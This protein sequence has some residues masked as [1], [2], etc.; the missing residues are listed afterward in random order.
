MKSIVIKIVTYNQEDV[1]G[2]ALDSVLRQ[3]EWGLYRIIVSDDCSTDRT[4]DVLQTYHAQYPDLVYIYRNEHNLGM[5]E[6]F[7]KSDSYIPDCDLYS[8]LAGDDEYCDGYFE[9]IQKFIVD[10]NIDTT[11]PIGIFS[12]WKSKSPN[13]VE[14][15]YSNSLIK[16]EY[17]AW[18]LKIRS[19]ITCRSLF[20]SKIVKDRAKPTIL[21]KGLRVA[22][23][24]YDVQSV[25]NIEKT[26]YMP[27]T[28]SIYYTEIGVSRKLNLNNSD[29]L[30]TQNIEKWKSFIELYIS[31][32]RDL[33]YANYE[34]TKSEYL[35]D[36]SW[37]KFFKIICH[38]HKGQLPK[39]K[40]SF[41]RSLHLYL[42]L[43]K[44]KFF[45]KKKA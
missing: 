8:G 4:W 41:N 9:A 28:T 33:N 36:P 35:L 25:L 13:G 17:S 30:T 42:G 20:V 37:E 7:Q 27:M 29:Y 14:T 18:Q 12:D 21:N 6:H 22:E 38:Y 1:V 40:D 10:N 24:N 2:R 16:S 32:N 26:Y 34:I 5:Y 19:K 3:K 44:Y 11:K 31:D 45:F 39:C 43:I 15:H 23:A